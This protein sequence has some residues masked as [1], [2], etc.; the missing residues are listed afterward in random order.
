[1]KG[2]LAAA[3]VCAALLPGA[4]L[5]QTDR[6]KVVLQVSDADPVK[7]N[8]ALNNARNLQTDLGR[9]R[10]EVEIVAYGPGLEMLKA[11][12][13]VSARLAQAI[14]S[15]I[16]LMACENTMRN[17]KVSKDDMYHGIRYVP[18]GVVHIVKR[19]REGWAYLRP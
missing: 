1:M 13:K 3:L 4:A 17:T 15:N 10:V 8:L 18:A 19:Q 14:D 9:D 11:E 2:V 16:G 12:S 7:W 6:Q 5:A